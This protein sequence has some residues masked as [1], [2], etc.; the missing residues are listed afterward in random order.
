FDLAVAA[1]G[2]AFGEDHAHELLQLGVQKV[3][4]LFD[5]DTAG[6]EGAVK[7]GHLFLKRGVEVNLANL[8]QGQDPHNLLSKRCP[9]AIS[10]AI[11]SAKDYLTFLV[12]HFSKNLKSNSPAE[13]N[14]MIQELVQ[15]IREWDNAVMV[16]ESLRKLSALTQ[17]PEDILGVGGVQPRSFAF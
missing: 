9:T 12:D 2:T 13:K 6:Q 3:L 8:S 1:L 5:G 10:Q 16:H 17:V 7:G 11:I 15:R 14:Q 4:L